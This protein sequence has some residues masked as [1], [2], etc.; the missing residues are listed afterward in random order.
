[1]SILSDLN[2]YTGE[3][4]HQLEIAITIRDPAHLIRVLQLAAPAHQRQYLQQR[5]DH[6]AIAHQRRER[7]KDL[8]GVSER[9]LPDFAVPVCTRHEDGA[10]LFGHLRRHRVKDDPPAQLFEETGRDLSLA[11]TSTPSRISTK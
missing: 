8:A 4:C 11:I 9:Y 7:L 10:D 2:S 1:M 3:Y 6:Q 5:K